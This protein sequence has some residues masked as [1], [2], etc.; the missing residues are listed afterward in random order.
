MRKTSQK[1]V[2]ANLRPPSVNLALS[3]SFN[4]KFLLTNEQQQFPRLVLELEEL[5]ETSIEHHEHASVL[6]VCKALTSLVDQ[7]AESQLGSVEP[8]RVRQVH[9]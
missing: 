9:N 6:S 4:L 1:L 2:H 7:S 8:S 3:H 5:N